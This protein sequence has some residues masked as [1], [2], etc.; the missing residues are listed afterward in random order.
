MEVDTRVK[1][2]AILL[3]LAVLAIL[4]LPDWLLA[5]VFALVGIAAAIEWSELCGF[6]PVLYENPLTTQRSL[7]I[8]AVIAGLLLAWVLRAGAIF[9]LTLISLIWGW[10]LVELIRNK[11]TLARPIG[12]AAIGWVAIVGCGLAFFV[13]IGEGDAGRKL[14]LSLLF[15]VWAADIGAYYTGRAFGRRALAPAISP[16]KTIEGA[17]GAMLL[18]LLVAALIGLL[19]WNSLS[20]LWLLLAIV[21][22]LVSIV[23]DLIESREK[24][25]SGKKDSG[26]LLPGHGGLLDRVDSTL[27]AAPVFTLGTLLPLA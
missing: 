18:S 22:T 25:A 13:L 21:V 27:A 2:A 23:G 19:L 9:Y 14:I 1:T 17:I 6:P 12:A 3:P 11:R 10:L 20:I 15:I 8:I 16:G 5:I 7:F 26:K 24:R 4:Y